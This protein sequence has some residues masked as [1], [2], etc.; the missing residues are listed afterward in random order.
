MVGIYKVDSDAD[1]LA[2]PAKLWV[3]WVG[4]EWT[5]FANR[6]YSISIVLKSF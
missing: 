1:H 6:L 3:W 2:V 4:M 5:A